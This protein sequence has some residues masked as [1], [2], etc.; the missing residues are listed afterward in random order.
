M[1]LQDQLRVKGESASQVLSTE[2]PLRVPAA[3]NVEWKKEASDLLWPKFENRLSPLFRD[4]GRWPGL[5]WSH[6]QH[7]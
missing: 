6:F 3:S 1:I 2:E 7:L 4:L 5:Q